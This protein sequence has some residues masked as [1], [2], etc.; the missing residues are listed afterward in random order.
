MA[1][2]WIDA[3]LS[4]PPLT[5]SIATDSGFWQESDPVAVLVRIGPDLVCGSGVW[6][7]YPMGCGWNGFT[8]DGDDLSC[9]TVKYWD[10][11]PK[12]PKEETC[13]KN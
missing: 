4:K 10:K 1:F 11:L 8:V 13:T 12:L 7:A 3:D 2:A 9:L 5:H 6:Y